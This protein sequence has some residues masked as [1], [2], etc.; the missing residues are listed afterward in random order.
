MDKTD[1][2][3]IKTPD[4]CLMAELI[5]RII[6]SRPL[7]TFSELSGVSVC[8][9]EDILA[10][11]YDQSLSLETIQ[12]IT[13]VQGEW[14]GNSLFMDVLKANGMASA[15]I[16]PSRDAEIQNK[17]ASMINVIVS[18]LFMRGYTMKP[19]GNMDEYR[20]NY[21]I[22][23]RRSDYEVY[24]VSNESNGV[25]FTWDLM[26]DLS[27]YPE[28]VPVLDD[29][30]SPMYDDFRI[31][32]MDAWTP[33]AIKADKISRLFLDRRVFDKYHESVCKY[34]INTDFSI[35]LIDIMEGRVIEE[36]NLGR[37]ITCDT[38]RL[39]QDGLEYLNR[40]YTDNNGDYYE[41][42]LHWLL[43]QKLNS[44]LQGGTS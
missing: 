3:N 5:T 27:I 6:D 28:S 31:F 21:P 39:F 12:K 18:E 35:I 41:D 22:L 20:E 2:L 26:T 24:E 34:Q 11:R 17:I 1:Y 4:K 36:R 19:V 38:A 33:G 43:V 15:S 13:S 9:L 10:G 42:W 8:D 29:V 32:L 25:R 16:P 23:F 30:F 44:M 7:D 37:Q 40:G 14:G